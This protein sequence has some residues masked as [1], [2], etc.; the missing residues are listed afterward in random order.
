MNN[1]W[2]QRQAGCLEQG[3]TLPIAQCAEAAVCWA[4]RLGK[5]H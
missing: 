2:V 1:A 4:L 5:P 3:V